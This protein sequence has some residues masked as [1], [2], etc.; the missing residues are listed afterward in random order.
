MWRKNWIFCF[1]IEVVKSDTP[2]FTTAMK[3]GRFQSFSF[4][5]TLICWKFHRVQNFFKKI[6]LDGFPEKGLREERRRLRS[7]QN[8]S[9]FISMTPEE[10]RVFI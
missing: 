5:E 4:S 9:P 8:Y 1:Y 7:T 6:F 3:C 10:K 2:R